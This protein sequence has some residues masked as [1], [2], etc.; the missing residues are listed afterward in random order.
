VSRPGRLGKASNA[1]LR[2]AL[3]RPALSTVRFHPN[4]NAFHEA[5]QK[6]GKKKIQ[7]LCA[8]MPKYLTSIRACIKL[9][10]PFNSNSL[11]SPIHLKNH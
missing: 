2:N 3:Y 9:N 6:R 7:A 5:L 4:A 10:T 1:C 8:V 11:F